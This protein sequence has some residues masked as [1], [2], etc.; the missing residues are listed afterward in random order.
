MEDWI[1]MKG[2]ILPSAKTQAVKAQ[3]LNWLEEDKTTKIVIYTQFLPMVRILGRICQTEGWDFVKYTGEMSHEAR[4]KSIREFGGKPA[5][6]IML[7]SLRAGGE[8]LNLVMATRVI[9]L[10]PWWNE[11][12]CD[13]PPIID[14]FLADVRSFT[15]RAAGF[16]QGKTPQ[17]S[18]ST[19]TKP[20]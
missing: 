16:L 5:I 14:L 3:V 6:K 8:G 15:G 10:D 7:A 11:A 9:C 19:E 1:A 20:C 2:E 4:A 12:V 18:M 13:P 17:S